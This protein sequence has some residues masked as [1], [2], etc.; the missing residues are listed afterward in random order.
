VLS[1]EEGVYLKMERPAG[2]A[3]PAAQA[4]ADQAKTDS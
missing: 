3:A 1:Q 4:R 2:G